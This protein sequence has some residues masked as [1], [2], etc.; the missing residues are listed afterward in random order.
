MSDKFSKPVAFKRTTLAAAIAL[1]FATQ[2]AFAGTPSSNQLPGKGVVTSGS[3]TSS[4]K[5]VPSSGAETITLGKN[6]VITWGGSGTPKINTGQ[7]GGFNIGS[8]AALTFSGSYPVLNIDASGNPS[9]IMGSLKSTGDLFVA[10]GNGIIV[11]GSGASITSTGGMVGLLGDS[12]SSSLNYPSGGLNTNSTYDGISINGQSGGNVTVSKNAS[13]SGSTVLIAS[14]G[15]VNVGDLSAVTSSGTSTAHTVLSAGLPINPTGFTSNN[16]NAV[17]TVSGQAQAYTTFQSAGKLVT[18]N[19]SSKNYTDFATKTQNNGTL[20]LKIGTLDNEGTL[21]ATNLNPSSSKFNT[22]N[23]GVINLATQSIIHLN[24]NV[25]NNGQFNIDSVSLGGSG[26]LQVTKQLY[27]LVKIQGGNLTNNG[28]IDGS[29]SPKTRSTPFTSLPAKTYPLYFDVHNGSIDNIGS[30]KNI[31]ELETASNSAQSGFTSGANYS[32]TNSGI[33][34]NT[35]NIKNRF[36]SI[37][38]Y[39]NYI[40]AAGGSNAPTNNSTGSV[41]NKGILQFGRKKNTNIIDAFAYNNVTMGGLVEQVAPGNTTPSAVSASNP[42]YNDRLVAGVKHLG[43]LN[44]SHIKYLPQG[45]LTLLTPLTTTGSSDLFGQQVKVMANLLSVTSASNS[46][47]TGLIDIKAGAKPESG[48]ALRV[49]KGKTVSANEVVVQGRNG[50]EHP[51]V[52]LQG[53]L[54][55]NTIQLGNTS[56]ANSYLNQTLF[57]KGGPVSDVFSG[58]KGGLKGISKTQKPR[59]LNKTRTKII[60]PTR[61]TTTNP[62]VVMN[63]T[64]R[65]KNATYL[66]KKISNFRYNDLPITSDGPVDLTLNPMSYTTNGTTGVSSSGSPSA[67]NILVNNTVNVHS[68]QQPTSVPNAGGTGVTGVNNWPNTHLVLQSTG[69][70]NL[71]SQVT[72]ATQGTS[73]PVNSF[74]W[75]GL[76]YLGT[77]KANKKTGK[78]EPGT[79][80][81][82]GTI[83]GNGNVNNVLPGSTAKGGGMHF[84]TALPLNLLTSGA[85]VVTNAHS[86]VNFSSDKLTNHYATANAKN[87]VFYGGSQGPGNVINYSVLPTKDFNTQL[88]DSTK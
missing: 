17:L 40:H 82:F 8:Q 22:L 53:T 33:I 78:P 51:N 87:M 42:L 6:T 79:L 12:S 14:G 74:Y 67:V 64:G 11:S 23:N 34:S 29:Y 63:F 46:T 88:P 45:T 41:T 60:K 69:N 84:E 58:P 66:S 7:P 35:S 81:D 72:A 70:I 48:Y 62:T 73:N 77:T 2:A 61:I 49:A 26:G 83:S 44:I 30:M 28:T 56:S 9:Q 20:T 18:T 80:S 47:R 57:R 5:N 86:Y 31:S 27:G 15:N 68:I 4:N 25:T 55:G 21:Y 36:D 52:I 50:I 76:V 75:P 39:A 32:L 85:T 13:I 3:V 24:G 1:T 37:F 71:K 19:T 16:T 38:L 65:I 54:S 59:V 10:N 43:N